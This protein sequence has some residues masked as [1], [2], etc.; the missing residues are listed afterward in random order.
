[1]ECVIFVPGIM[2][3]RLATPEGE[4]IWP[5]TVLETQTGYGRRE[6]LERDDLVVTDIVRKV[7]CV[8][9][10][11]PLVDQFLAMGFKE[12]GVGQKRLVAFAYDWRRDLENTKDLLAKEIE[13]QVKAGAK[14]I[15]IVGHSMGGL[16]SRLLLESGVFSNEPWFK[17]IISFIALATPHLGAPLALARILGMDS[18]LG[19]S[20]SDFK[21]FANNPKYPTAYQLLPAPGEAACWDISVRSLPALDIY[22]SKVAARLGLNT[23]LLKRA[24]YVHDTLGKNSAPENVRYFFFAGTGHGTVTRVNVGIGANVLTSSEDAGDGTVPLWSALPRS[25]QKQ[26]VVGEHSGF[27]VGDAFSAVF[28][29]LLGADFP[30]PPIALHGASSVAL[31]MKQLL[32]PKEEAPEVVL[33]PDLPTNKIAGQLFLERTEKPEAPFVA[34]GE[35]VPVSYNGPDIALLKF[36]LPPLNETGQY[37]VTFKG[38]PGPS[39]PVFFAVWA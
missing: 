38:K 10:Y 7:W 22:D 19:I 3:S 23:S 2:G 35:P 30:E 9:V 6:E 14:S 21:I 31:S 36:I 15:I 12:G 8:G 4:E 37:R 32:L 28:Y 27:F 18:A 39:E 17:K 33:I 25:L 20:K 24:R 11:Q 16:V 1:M 13:K 34:F 29:R 5:P 26:L